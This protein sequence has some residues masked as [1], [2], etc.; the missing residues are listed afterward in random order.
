[1][2]KFVFITLFLALSATGHA[3]EQDIASVSPRHNEVFYKYSNDE[4]ESGFGIEPVQADTVPKA[5][6]VNGVKKND[7][8]SRLMAA[9]VNDT[10]VLYNTYV[11]VLPV[12]DTV[13]TEIAKKPLVKADSMVTK[14]VAVVK[15]KPDSIQKKPVVTLTVPPKKDTP[16]A[17]MA[18]KASIQKLYEQQSDSALQLVYVDMSKQGNK[19]TVNIFIPVETVNNDSK[20]LMLADTAKKTSDAVMVT[21]VK[22]EPEPEPRKDTATAMVARNDSTAPI[23]MKEEK[24]NP[25]VAVITKPADSNNNNTKAVA[26][27]AGTEKQPVTVATWPVVNTNCK[28]SATDY[29]VDKLRVKMLA[30]DSEDD[31]MLVAKKLFRVKCFTTRSVLY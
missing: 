4:S 3:Q 24:S 2:S 30:V 17:D 31:K 19:D 26:P 13:R 5:S 27:P 20:P 22:K 7:A 12:K 16:Q 15:T 10:S 11:E 21:P 8:F 28:N 23:V 1:M 18:Q 9:V 6:L 29:D 25:P 14:P